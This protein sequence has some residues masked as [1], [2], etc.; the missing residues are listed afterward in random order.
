MKIFVMLL[1]VPLLFAAVV[2]A[3]GQQTGPAI[4]LPEAAGDGTKSL[5]KCISLRRS[6]RSF[7]AEPVTLPQVSQLLWAGQ[8]ITGRERSLRAAPSAGALYPLEVYLVAA[9][10]KGLEPGVYKYQPATHELGRV[11]AGDRKE[12]LAGAAFN[13]SSIVT[14]PAALVIAAVYERTTRKYGERGIRYVHVDAGAAAENMFLEAVSQ[15]LG[16]VIAG[17]F[18]DEGVRKAVGMAKDER[19]LLIMPIGT[20]K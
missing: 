10:V 18:D 20:P 3:H 11:V 4:K 13:Q 2:S 17:S 15:G 1:C 6:V 8:G 7:G 19:P 14:A 12:Q 9:R 5:E 16:T